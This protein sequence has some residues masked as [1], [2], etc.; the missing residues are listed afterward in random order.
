MAD[1][2]IE[3][4][5]LVFGY[6]VGGF[7]L[8]VSA[9]RIG[10]GEKMAVT[11]PSGS[12][13]T[14]LLNL[15]AGILVPSAGQI[16]VL[17]IEVSSLSAE[18]RQ[19]FRALRMGLVFQEFELLEYLDVLDNVLLPWRVSPVLHLDGEVRAR[20]AELLDDVGLADKLH[21]YPGSLSQGE[22]QRVAVCRALVTKPAIIFGDEPTG[23]L[24]S[25]NRDHVMK[26]LFRYSADTKAPLIVVTHDHE[27]IGRFDRAIDVRELAA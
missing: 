7:R 15:L 14:T 13:K 1:I 11:G 25:S 22:R 9:L 3:V 8:G 10:P 21:R 20:A 12:G 18:D 19:D 26:I 17:K 5:N 24:D 2:V 6:R 4:K 27:L 23:N 16:R